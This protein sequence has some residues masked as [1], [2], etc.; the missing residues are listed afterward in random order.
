MNFSRFDFRF[1]R[2][3]AG[4]GAERR[5]AVCRT[6]VCRAAQRRDVGEPAQDAENLIA[7]VYRKAIDAETGQRA[8]ADAGRDLSQSLLDAR[9][10]IPKD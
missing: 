3:H 4:R 10:E 9:V 8:F 2:A 6:P 1:P 5:R 7:H